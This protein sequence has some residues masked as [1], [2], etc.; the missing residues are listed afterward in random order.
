MLCV[1]ET[2]LYN[3][4]IQLLSRIL[5]Q[6]HHSIDVN[7]WQI[8]ALEFHFPG[9]RKGRAGAGWGR[10]CLRSVSI[11]II[12]VTHHFPSLHHSCGIT[13]LYPDTRSLPQHPVS[14]HWTPCTSWGRML[15]SWIGSLT[16]QSAIT[17]TR[18]VWNDTQPPVHRVQIIYIAGHGTLSIVR[19]TLYCIICVKTKIPLH[20]TYI[21]NMH[22]YVVC[23]VNSWMIME[24]CKRKHIM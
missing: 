12:I 8:Q 24:N 5:L 19:K 7:T 15:T 6:R 17:V 14:T 3:P 22:F 23:N 13:A 4:I 2:V 10:V 21:I 18:S 16:Q 20:K 1:G 11:I 9:V